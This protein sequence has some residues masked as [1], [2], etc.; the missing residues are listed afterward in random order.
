MGIPLH[1]DSHVHV[2]LK[3]DR[4]PDLGGFSSWYLQQLTFK[5]F[6]LYGR[7]QPHT[8]SDTILYNASI[9]TLTTCGLD[10][11]VC[12]A[13]DPVYDEKTG[14]EQRSR[15]HVWVSNEYV[16]KLQQDVAAT[17]GPKVLLGASVHPYDM[18][19]EARVQHYV[20]KGAVL[21]KWLPS[22]QQIDL[23]DSRVL[24]RL[25]FLAT[26]KN[27]K[28]L[29]L[30]LHVGPEYAIPSTDEST[31]TYDFLGWSWTE[32]MINAFRGNKKWRTPNVDGIHKNL[33][34]GLDAGATIIFA[35]CGLPYFTSGFLASL[36]EHSDFEIIK[37]YLADYG[38]T[39]T[40]G[41]CYADVSAFCTPFRKTFFPDVKKL[42]AESILFGSDFP[43]PAF[44][45]SADIQENLKDFKAVLEGQFDRI[46]IPQ[47]NLLDVNYR[48]LRL[49][50][51]GHPMFTNFSELIG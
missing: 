14:T 8:V 38:K 39:S 17:H 50:F 29:P 31:K 42:P 6:L 16:L 1:I 4:W 25:K 22:A 11:V 21:L 3:G 41:R 15:S 24:A 48:E 45:L 23:A 34:G 19:F 10:R 20:A 46:V 49:A 32:R 43:T 37:K 40:K 28:P 35:H 12:L 47:D 44:E 7:I 13:L 36:F 51:P 5:I 26:A 33:R 9:K 18:N 2:G 30:L 27:G